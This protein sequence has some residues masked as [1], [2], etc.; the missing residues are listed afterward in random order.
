MRKGDVNLDGKVDISD[1]SAL[2]N[3]LIGIDAETESA[4][5]NKDGS[6]DIS[7]ITELLNVLGGKRKIVIDPGHGK[8]TNR[9][10]VLPEFMEGT[11]NFVLGQKL[12]AALEKKGFLVVIT[13]QN[14]ED[15]PSLS[16]RGGM[17]RGA[18][19]FISLHSNA[20][21][22]Q[23]DE[24]GQTY[25][26][27]TKR[28]VVTCYSIKDKRETPHLC[29][30]FTAVVSRLMNTPD[31]LS[32]SQE[33]TVNPGR[34]Y[35]GVLRSSSEAG[36]PYCFI[37]EHGF[38][39][40]LDDAKWLMSDSNLQKL[41]DAEAELIYNWFNPVIYRVQV[42]AYFA[43]SNAQKAMKNLQASGHTD[44]Y[45]VDAGL[46]YRV[47]VGAYN[48]RKYALAKIDELKKDGFDAILV[49][50]KVEKGK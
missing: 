45:I 12:K 2:Q 29:E 19:L 42:G 21:S 27:P 50:E 16:V 28:G 31:L 34:D 43:K 18:D 44:A 36:C 39:T 33:S 20:P 25:Y 15:D 46:F 32:F 30:D 24:K 14:I 9:S 22:A 38:H 7:D 5:V 49:Q 6:V 8:T 40:N 4:D 11:R 35:F 37:I 1:V 41:A 23:K 47:Q 10:P 48:Y 17:A 26:D 13:R 3:M